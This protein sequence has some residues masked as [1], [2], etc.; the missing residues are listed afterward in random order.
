MIIVFLVL[1][2]YI[3]LASRNI[4]LSFLMLFFLNLSVMLGLI[5]YDALVIDW[6]VIGHWRPAFLHLPESMQATEMKTHIKRS[7]VAAPVFGILL[8]FVATV[9]SYY[10][11]MLA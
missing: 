7:L 2:N 9:I 4:T 5:L 10:I 11:W 8:A 3:G 6:L 1:T